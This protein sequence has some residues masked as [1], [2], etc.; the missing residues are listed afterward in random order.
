MSET[1]VSGR[2]EVFSVNSCGHSAIAA[3]IPVIHFLRS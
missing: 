2:R 3:P 1:A